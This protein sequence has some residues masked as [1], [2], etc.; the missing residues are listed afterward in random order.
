MGDTRGDVA[1]VPCRVGLYRYLLVYARCLEGSGP[2]GSPPGAGPPSRRKLTCLVYLNTGWADGD[3]GELELVP[4]LR[5]PVA[6]PPLATQPRSRS[7]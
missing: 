6:V 2:R 3:G 4:W 1:S 7:A 5:P